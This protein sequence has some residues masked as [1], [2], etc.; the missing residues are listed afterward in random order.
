[1]QRLVV[2]QNRERLESVRGVNLDEEAADM[3][4]FEQMYQA[5]ARVMQVSDSLFQT[6]M[7]TLLR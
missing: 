6:L 4:R 5:A 1:V 2:D 7:N 3:L